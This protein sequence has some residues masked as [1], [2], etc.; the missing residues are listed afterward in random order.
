[1]HYHQ[2][3]YTHMDIDENM[4]HKII[5]INSFAMCYKDGLQKK[6]FFFNSIIIK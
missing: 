6:C 2:C 5:N 1:M 4:Y 3:V